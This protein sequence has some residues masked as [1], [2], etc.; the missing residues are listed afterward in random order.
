MQVRSPPHLRMY[1]HI[2]RVPF[3]NRVLSGIL[4]PNREEVTDSW[5][6]LHNKGP[7]DLYSSQNIIWYDQINE[8][9]IGRTC[10]M[11]EED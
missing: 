1:A 11:H 7:D 5:I 2:M 9:K 6:K 4:D 10:G 8:D 3:E